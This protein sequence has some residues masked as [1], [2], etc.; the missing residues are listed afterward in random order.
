MSGSYLSVADNG[1]WRQTYAIRPGYY[2]CQAINICISDR[3]G[4]T[5]AAASL[6]RATRNRNPSK[7]PLVRCMRY[8]GPRRQKLHLQ[9]IVE[10]WSYTAECV[11]HRYMRQNAIEQKTCE[12]PRTALRL[13]RA[14]VL[15]P[16]RRLLTNRLK[17]LSDF[18]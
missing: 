12:L 7:S 15:W 8:G 10:C 1:S 18:R 6:R 3:P 11:E 14:R 5:H 2:R 4:S 9:P 13:V 16:K 17:T